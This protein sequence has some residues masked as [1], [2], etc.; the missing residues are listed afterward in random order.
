MKLD[1]REAQKKIGD[2]LFVQKFFIHPEKFQNYF[3]EI[4]EKFL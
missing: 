2:M 3:E 1:M 4:P